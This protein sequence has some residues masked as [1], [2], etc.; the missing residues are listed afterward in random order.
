MLR[1]PLSLP[2]Q[3]VLEVIIFVIPAL[4]TY[5]VLIKNKSY[6]VCYGVKYEVQ[7]LNQLRDRDSQLTVYQVELAENKHCMSKTTIL[8]QFLPSVFCWVKKKC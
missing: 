1:S 2:P 5:K 4:I 7:K 8:M 6:K 3:D